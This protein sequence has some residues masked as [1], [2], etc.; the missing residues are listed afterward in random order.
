[1][2]QDGKLEVTLPGYAFA[3]DGLLIYEALEKFMGDYLRLYY[4]DEDGKRVRSR[5]FFV[6]PTPI[7]QHDVVHLGAGCFFRVLQDADMQ[8]GFLRTFNIEVYTLSPG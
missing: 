2:G 4:S 1:M 7:D 5:T 6:A 3:E 8:G